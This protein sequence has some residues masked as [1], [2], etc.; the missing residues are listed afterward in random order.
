MIQIVVGE[1][2]S[3]IK[4][5]Q[6]II[7]ELS[8]VLKFEVD[9]N[10]RQKSAREIP[11]FQK[12]ITPKGRF[13]S[14]LLDLV[15]RTLKKWDLPYEVIDNCKIHS[16]PD[17]EEV[18]NSL[19]KLRDLDPPITLR[20]YQAEAVLKGLQRLRGIFHVATG[21]GKTLIMS[22]LVMAWGKRTLVLVGSKDLAKQLRDQLERF[23][24]EDVG[25]IGNGVHIERRV[26]VGMIQTLSTGAKS[27]SR[28]K[29]DALSEFLES[30]EYI[31]IDEAHHVQA[32]TWKEVL[33]KCKNA[34]IRHGYTATPLTSKIKTEDRQESNSNIVLVA[35]MGPV[36]FKK[37]TQDLIEDG[38]LARPYI[39]MI[40]N[41][42][43][44]DKNYLPYVEEYERCIVSDKER[45]NLACRIFNKAYQDRVPCIGFV[46]RLDHGENIAEMLEDEFSIEP[47]D[48]GFIHGELFEK[49]RYG[50]LDSFRDGEL[51]IMFG[52]VLSE[53]IDFNCK[54]AIN[55]SGGDSDIA[56]IQRLG[57]VLRKPRCPILND[58][59]LAKSY[60]VVFVDFGD[61]GHK[62]FRKHARNRARVYEVEG[63]TVRTVE[64]D[65]FDEFLEG[66]SNVYSAESKEGDI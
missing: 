39:Y 58:V 30:I 59:D 66:L 63:H 18:S 13:L 21:G 16:H 62:W 36:I 64:L 27:K 6:E 51:P 3:N 46:T 15:K 28:K 7:E 35:Y 34:S 8:E 48:I 5:D 10:L 33:R 37:T 14:G 20:E 1:V 61:Y 65:N 17:L 50:I 56:A 32:A 29:R 49:D 53:G 11:R 12:L 45:N 60:S 24:G 54:L 9:F 38:Y 42:V 52:T 2:Y 41:R 22:S 44:N 25:M 55:V 4:C 40:D 47:S 57:R 31:V 43:F 19:M 26:T 23:L